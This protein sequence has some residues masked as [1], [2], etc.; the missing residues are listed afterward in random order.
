[1]NKSESIAALA[2]ALSKAQAEMA[3]AKKD[4]ANPFFKSKYADLASVWEACRE[5]FGKYGLSVSQMPEMRDSQVIVHSILMHSS[6]EWISGELSMTPVKADPQGVGSCITYARRYALAAIA[7]IA[8]EDDDGNQ[9]SGRKDGQ[10]RTTEPIPV[11]PLISAGASKGQAAQPA[12]PASVAPAEASER[13][14]GS[15]DE[16]LIDLPRQKRIHR[17]F[18]EALKN[19]EAQKQSDTWLRT[20]LEKQGYK[21]ADGNGTTRTIPLYLF[22]EVLKEAAEFAASLPK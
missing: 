20:W 16:E 9:A 2:E 14:P 8:P 12:Q 13:Q 21:D 11:A 4:A 17:A 18:R 1:M 22:E 5:P 10:Q 7:G 6:G 19:P 3:G 15:D